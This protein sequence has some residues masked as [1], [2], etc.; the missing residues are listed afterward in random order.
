M[1][2]RDRQDSKPTSEIAGRAASPELRRAHPAPGKQTLVQHLAT[3]GPSSGTGPHEPTQPAP[4]HAA[5]AAGVAGTSQ[6]LPFA[7]TIQQLFGRHDISNVEAHTDASAAA[8]SRAMGAQAFAAGNHVA[9]GSTP[10]LHTAA[11][12]AAHVVQQGGGVQ[13]KGGV[14]EVG[15]PHE[16]HANQ[17][18]DRVVAGKP[19][20]DLLDRYAAGSTATTIGQSGQAGVQ[21]EAAAEGA[22]GRTG[23]ATTPKPATTSHTAH[24]G[25]SDASR[26][27][28]A[29]PVLPVEHEDHKLKIELG[30]G[31]ITGAITLAFEFGKT[32][33]PV[34]ATSLRSRTRCR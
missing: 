1:S 18:A 22:T 9:F 3:P 10:D 32:G 31:S 30:R 23:S 4:V 8:G 24:G 13:L 29:E 12:E 19:V 7:D 27:G 21:R 16:Q 14:G 25:P 17:V 6:R 20:E 26:G 28:G 15:D 2:Q 5:A 11:H 33:V 34:G